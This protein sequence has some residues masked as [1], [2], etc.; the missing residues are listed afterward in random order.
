MITENNISSTPLILIIDDEESNLQLLCSILTDYKKSL[1]TSGREGI[2]LAKK[3]KPDLI[4]LDILMPEIDGFEVCKTLKAD[5]SLSEIPIIFLTSKNQPDDIV[6]ALEIGA[7]DYISKPFNRNELLARIRTHLE[8]KKSKDL[9]SLQNIQLTK[10]NDDKSNF[11]SIAAHD[12]KN[13]LMV[14]HGFSKLLK[15]QIYKYSTENILD[16]SNDIFWGTEAMISIIN[17]L[18]LVSD[19][20]DDKIK[21]IPEEINLIDFIETIIGEF[22][23]SIKA[24]NILVDIDYQATDIVIVSDVNLLSI[25]LKNLISNALKFSPRDTDI[26]VNVLPDTISNINEELNIEILDR[27]PGIMEDEVEK[28]FKKFSVLSSETTNNELMIG[29]GLAI[30]EMASKLLNGKLYYDKN[31]DN[32]AKFVLSIPLK[33]TN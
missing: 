29:L 26:A 5:K 3:L 25:C 16:I 19:L 8:L 30:S 31:Y 27:G 4:L 20:E 7:V 9:I 6:E 13:I 10:L 24:K 14:I 23:E 15:N 22:E 33:L 1:A 18:V 2:N 17:N 11:L 28:L 12:V 32:G 21:P